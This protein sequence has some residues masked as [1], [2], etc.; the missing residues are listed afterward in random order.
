MTLLMICGSTLLATYWTM[1]I[2]QISHLS[3]EKLDAL[4]QGDLRQGRRFLT[5]L[6]S[7]LFPPSLIG[8]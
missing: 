3:D 6:R 7:T 8:V 2:W 4:L 5:M 1:R